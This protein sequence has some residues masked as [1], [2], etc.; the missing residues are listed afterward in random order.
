MIVDDEA[1]LCELIELQIKSNFEV[2]TREARDGVH[3]LKVFNEQGPFDAIISDYRMPRK[4][5][6]ELIQEIR[7]VHPDI[8]F[9]LCSA[10]VHSIKSLFENFKHVEFLEKPFFGDSLIMKLLD[11]LADKKPPEQSLNYLPV[12]LD[13]LRRLESPGVNLFIRLND[14]HFVKVLK[15]FSVFTEQELKR[16][17]RKNLTHLFVSSNDFNSFLNQYR[18]NIFSKIEWKNLDT[19]TAILNL[20]QDWALVIEANRMFGWSESLMNT[21]KENIAKTIELAKSNPKLIKIFERL[22]L[23]ENRSFLIPHSYSI[24]FFCTQIVKELGWSSENT[25]QKLTF[26]GLFHD[27]ELTETMFNNKIRLIESGQLDQEVHQP[28]NYQ[29][30][31]HPEQGA[32]LMREWSC[33]PPDVDH[34]IAQHHEK[35]D[36][37]GFPNKLNFQTISPLAGLFIMAEDVVYQK[38]NH[39][40][41]S[42]VKFLSEKQE[43]YSRGDMRTIYDCILNL[44]ISI[45]QNASIQKKN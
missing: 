45:D 38:I 31:R 14:A 43:L 17:Q 16:F 29:I 4:N 26:A 5:G 35:F 34:I 41:D 15:E 7:K 18:K 13:L 6:F 9:L 23:R 3:A 12:S 25:L 11:L 20:E 44:A 32:E 36:G 27:I 42:L 21:A 2:E 8:P 30:F 19:K 37:T 28:T 39:P 10:E 33:C 40:Q 1:E 22:N 24:I